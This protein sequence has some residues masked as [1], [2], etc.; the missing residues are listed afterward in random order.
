MSGSVVTP[1]S[2]SYEKNTLTNYLCI[3][4]TSL[5]IIESNT[6]STFT[7]NGTPDSSA[8]TF[9]IYKLGIQIWYSRIPTYL[10][11]G[12][13][14]MPGQ[15]IDTNLICMR[16]ARDLLTMLPKTEERIKSILNISR[17]I[18]D[19]Y[20]IVISNKYA[21]TAGAP[22]TITPLKLR[23]DAAGYDDISGTTTDESE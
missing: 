21:K 11:S 10:T 20:R 6:T 17:K 15:D 7:V 22:L 4:G 18:E 8:V 1:S 9:T 19:K 13:D 16:A 14:N 12:T 3:V 2:F 23:S 5:F